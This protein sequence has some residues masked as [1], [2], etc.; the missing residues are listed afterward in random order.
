MQAGERVAG[1][2]RAFGSAVGQRFGDE[3][4]R[5]MLRAGGQ[6]G[7]I[8]TPSVALEHWRELDRVAELTGVLKA[9]G[10]DNAEECG[11]DNVFC[12]AVQTWHG[13]GDH[14]DGCL[15]FPC[16]KPAS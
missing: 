9:S 11:C 15:T 1:E 8:T 10:R 7:A 12:R 14:T 6:P 16:G 5:A 3:G 4:V 13:A 2:L